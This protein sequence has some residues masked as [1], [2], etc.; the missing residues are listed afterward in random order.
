V[1]DRDRV[2]HSHGHDGHPFEG[3]NR[4]GRDGLGMENALDGESAHGHHEELDHDHV[5]DHV[6]SQTAKT[7]KEEYEPTGCEISF[8]YS[9]VSGVSR[10]KGELTSIFNTSSRPKRLLCIS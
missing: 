8:L 2:S 5:Q 4:H 9:K 7:P 3:S 1:N 10:L 6:Q